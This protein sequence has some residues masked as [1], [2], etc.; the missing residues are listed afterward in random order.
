MMIT[1]YLIIN[2]VDHDKMSILH[3]EAR[4]LF[5]YFNNITN[6]IAYW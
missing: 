4:K 2:R 3:Y 5:S 1:L 6:V